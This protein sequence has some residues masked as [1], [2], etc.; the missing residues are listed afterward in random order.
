MG[1]DSHFV[2]GSV[3]GVLSVAVPLMNSDTSQVA[4]LVRATDSGTPPLFSD[5]NVTI[6]LLT[7]GST[8][9]DTACPPVA[10]ILHCEESS[11]SCCSRCEQ[12]Y[13]WG[14][15]ACDACPPPHAGCRDV[16]CMSPSNVSCTSCHP[17]FYLKGSTCLEGSVAGDTTDPEEASNVIYIVVGAVGGAVAGCF[18]TAVI[19]IVW[20]K[21]R[22]KP[23]EDNANNTN[24][25]TSA[26]HYEDVDNHYSKIEMRYV[27]TRGITET[28]TPDYVNGT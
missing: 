11:S 27:N 26:S 10:P 16:I 2:V 3:T 14:A 28:G 7:P 1:L 12:G 23:R 5:V 8:C 17:G 24:M 20:M 6:S 13:F 4:V 19:V 25:Y 22:T 9:G 18:V 15:A 21:R